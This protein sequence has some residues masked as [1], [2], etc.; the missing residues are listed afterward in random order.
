MD[1]KFEILKE[2]N[3]LIQQRSGLY[4]IKALMETVQQCQTHPDY[5]DKLGMLSDFRKVSFNFDIKIFEDFI[6]RYSETNYLKAK[7]A[8]IVENPENTALATIWEYTIKQQYV[9]LFSTV[10]G[11]CNWLNVDYSIVKEYFD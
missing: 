11:A 9:K 3:L 1:F 7:F 5:S 6:K 2:Q 4:T 8:I 10:K